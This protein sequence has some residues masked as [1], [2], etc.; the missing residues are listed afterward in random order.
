M[1]DLRPQHVTHLV[2]AS[3][4]HTGKVQKMFPENHSGTGTVVALIPMARDPSRELPGMCGISCWDVLG[5]GA[6]AGKG[7]TKFIGRC[8]CPT[9]LGMFMLVL[10]GVWIPKKL[11]CS[12]KNVA[13]CVIA[14]LE[15]SLKPGEIFLTFSRTYPLDSSFDSSHSWSLCS[16]DLGLNMLDK[17]ISKL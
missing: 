10:T 12:P 16:V 2:R 3:C 9:I 5:M 11:A 4:S 7:A 14:T 1:S 13:R 17:Q 15:S 6:R 8:V